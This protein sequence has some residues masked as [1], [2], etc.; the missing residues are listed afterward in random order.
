MRVLQPSANRKNK[1]REG[2]KEVMSLR[3]SSSFEA[4]AAKKT[5]CLLEPLAS[6]DKIGQMMRKEHSSRDG[7]Q[8]IKEEIHKLRTESPQFTG[9]GLGQHRSKS[10]F[11]DHPTKI[12]RM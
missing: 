12:K 8:S 4:V 3:L 11:F 2:N 6:V 7:I 9:F 10:F 1:D 5:T